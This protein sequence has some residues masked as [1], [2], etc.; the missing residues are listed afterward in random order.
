MRFKQLLAYFKATPDNNTTAALA[1]ER[2]QIVISHERSM[3]HKNMR[4]PDFLPKMQKE[5]LAVI[6][7]YFP[8]D[9]DQVKVEF[10]RTDDCSIIELN[11]TLPDAVTT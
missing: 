7:K 11:V 9:P 2:L 5:L 1:K 10:E 3:Q 4:Q 6:S 8:V